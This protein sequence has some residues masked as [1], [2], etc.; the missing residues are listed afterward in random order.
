I[1]RAIMATHAMDPKEATNV[2]HY[3]VEWLNNRVIK[4]ERVSP[5]GNTTQT[6]LVDYKPDGTRVEHVRNA[7]GIEIYNDSV[8]RTAVVTR[9]WRSGEVIYDGCYWRRRAFDSFGRLE[10]DTCLDDKSM[11]ATD[12]NGCA[13]VRYQWSVSNDVQ[14]KVCLKNDMSAT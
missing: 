1:G 12:A 9:T 2:W 4:Y 7:Y 13:V 3:R 11:V 14:T 8:D 10:T 5:G 6:V